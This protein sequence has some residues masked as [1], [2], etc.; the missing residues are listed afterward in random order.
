MIGL[1]QQF[2][3]VAKAAVRRGE[4]RGVNVPM[5]RNDR[6]VLDPGIQI[7]SDGLLLRFWIEKAIG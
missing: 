6:Q 3:G 5:W 2:D 1:D 4:E 7:Q